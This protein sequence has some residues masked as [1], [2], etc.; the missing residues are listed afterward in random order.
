MAR[1]LILSYAGCGTCQKALKWLAARDLQADVRPI[2]EQ[3][4]TPAELARWIPA[5][6]LPVRKWLNTSGL[7]YRAL[8]K[9][10]ID[11]ASEETLRQWLSNDGKLVK[12][13][14]LVA[15]GQVRVGFKEEEWAALLEQT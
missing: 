12:R 1:P 4:P 14:V 3:P 6:G 8:G 15:G 10:K 9:A 7:S 11:A 5:S 2:V 13:P